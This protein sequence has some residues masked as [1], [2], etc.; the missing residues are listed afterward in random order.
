MSKIIFVGIHNA[1]G[2]TPLDSS[3]YTGRAVDEI[4]AKVFIGIKCVKSN[5]W[6]QTTPPNI[7]RRTFGQQM[8]H[9]TDWIKRTDYKQ[10]DIIISLGE[11]VH[12]VFS[13]WMKVEKNDQH[14]IFKVAHPSSHVA[15]MKRAEYIKSTQNGISQILMYYGKG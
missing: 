2:K 7:T 12:G 14:R 11:L 5:L 4:I 1:P 9:V 15:R 6:D 3:T 13:Y 8:G 10:G